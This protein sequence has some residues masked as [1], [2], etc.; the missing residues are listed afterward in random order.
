MRQVTPRKISESAVAA[1]SK[2]RTSP[3]FFSSSTSRRYSTTPKPA[4]RRW[5]TRDFPRNPEE[6]VTP[7]TCPVRSATIVFHDG[8]GDTVRVGH[9]R[10]R[11]CC[12]RN[13][14]EHRRIREVDI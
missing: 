6:P 4:P 11:E 14:R 1:R 3:C 9:Y 8:A 10:E 7:T 13:R 12:R 2:Y 5:E